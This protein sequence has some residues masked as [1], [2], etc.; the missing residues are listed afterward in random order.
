LSWAPMRLGVDQYRPMLSPSGVLLGNTDCI[1]FSAGCLLAW[2][3][4]PGPRTRI[5]SNTKKKIRYFVNILL[6][7]IFT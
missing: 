4:L 7:T 6:K 1:G 5:K 2:C 3:A